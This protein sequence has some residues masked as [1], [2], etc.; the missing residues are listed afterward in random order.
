MKTILSLLF[1]TILLFLGLTSCIEDGVTT[2]PSAQPLFSVDTLSLG[3]TFTDQ[4]TPTA[5]FTV[6]NRNSKIISISRIALREGDSAPFRINVDG[7]AGREFTNVEIRPSDSIFILVE[8]TLPPNH[9]PR[10]TEVLSNLD[11][12]TNG[13]T[14]SVVLKAEGQDVERK[15]GYIVTADER[16]TAEYPYQIYDSLVVAEGATLTL[17]PGVSLHFHDKAEMRVYGTLITEG[18]PELPVNMTGDRTDNVVG[19]ISFDLMA[20]QWEGLTLMPRSRGNRLSHTIVRNTVNGVWADSLS[21]AEFINCR[22]RNAANYPLVS[23]HAR[24]TLAGTEVAEGGSGLYAIVGGDVTANHCTFANY[25]LFTALRGPALQFFHVDEETSLADADAP[26]LKADFTNSIFYGLGT[27]MNIGDFSGTDVTFRSCVFKSSGEDD[28][29]FIT[30]IW[31][32]DPL[33]G[34]VRE[35][36]YFDYR[37]LPD[38]PVRGLADPALTLPITSHDF[39]G[40]PRLPAPTHGAYQ[41]SH[42]API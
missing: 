20:S 34:T 28:D 42:P 21:Q 39:Y 35:D 13:V 11:F 14:G 41:Q 17:D 4:P 6:H 9:S 18:T 22:L 15:R 40:E 12:T 32:T 2:S 3:V 29:H 16:W 10:L 8:A 38:S 36:Y 26:Y 27:D 24:I 37:L 19:D 25:Y 30:C 33:Y 31:D 1:S 7:F 23:R 5:R